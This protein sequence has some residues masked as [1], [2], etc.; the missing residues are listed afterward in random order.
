MRRDA[1][2]TEDGDELQLVGDE[3]PPDPNEEP[4]E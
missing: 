4:I 2:K 1:M 3:M